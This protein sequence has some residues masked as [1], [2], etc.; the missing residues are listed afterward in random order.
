VPT[1]AE[2]GH[3]DYTAT[4]WFGLLVRSDTPKPVVERLLKAA[5]AAHSDPAV[6]KK[7]EDI[8]FDVPGLTGPAFANEIVKQTER[9]RALVKLTGF[10]VN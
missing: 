9:W 4:I 7:L 5:K 6:K 8:G 2:L 10:K 3:D 1:F